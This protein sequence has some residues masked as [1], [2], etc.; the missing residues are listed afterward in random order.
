MS[1][2]EC[3]AT[4]GINIICYTLGNSSHLSTRP[5]G[6]K[7]RCRVVET[8]S[9]R[10]RA[11]ISRAA[12]KRSVTPYVKGKHARGLSST[13]SDYLRSPT[14]RALVN[15][16]RTARRIRFAIGAPKRGLVEYLRLDRCG[17]HL[18]LLRI[19]RALINPKVMVLGSSPPQA[20]RTYFQRD[21]TACQ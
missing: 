18:H 2:N 13:L 16:Y 8:A 14:F 9:R 11:Y 3:N 7:L 4:K 12:A 6:R 21:D 17:G 1:R 10:W 15:K 5:G 20:A 19:C